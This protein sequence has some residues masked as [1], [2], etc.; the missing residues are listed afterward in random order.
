MRPEKQLL[1]DDLK[2]M[3]E[4]SSAVFITK[5]KALSPNKAS[6][7]RFNLAK[8]GGSLEVV[9]KRIFLKAAQA[10]GITFDRGL[11]EGNIG[12]VFASEDPVEVT[13]QVFEFGKEAESQ[14]EVLT[15]QFEG[16]ILSAKDIEILSKLPSKD[17][18]RSE[19]IGLLVAPMTQTLSV[20]EELLTSVMHCLENKSKL[21]DE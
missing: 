8:V 12:I 13:K 21:S 7:F 1:L 9:K 19:L 14:L 4:N 3:I 6:E 15:G 16:S 2:E 5:Y 11:F 10:A 17:Q 18:L 20:M